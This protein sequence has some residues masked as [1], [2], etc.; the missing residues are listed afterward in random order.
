MHIAVNILLNPL[1]K[2]AMSALTLGLLCRYP[3]ASLK[4]LIALLATLSA[5]SHARNI[6]RLEAGVCAFL[7][8]STIATGL[9]QRTSP[10]NT[11]TQSTRYNL[12]DPNYR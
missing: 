6:R 7:Y 8:R 5:K 2:Q 4:Q 3:E 10:R 11:N 9:Y 12:P 1:F